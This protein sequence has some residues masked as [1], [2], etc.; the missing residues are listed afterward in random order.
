MYTCTYAPGPRCADPPA[1]TET[2][3]PPPTSPRTA[4][5][6]EALPPPPTPSTSWLGH[7]S[8][9]SLWSPWL[10]SMSPHTTRGCHP[11]VTPMPRLPLQP[12][13]PR[14]PAAAADGRGAQHIPSQITPLSC[15]HPPASQT[16]GI[17]VHHHMAP[18][19]QTITH[20]PMAPPPAT[21]PT[22]PPA[23]AGSSTGGCACPAPL[24]PSL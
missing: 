22:T 6:P 15:S 10:R 13:P 1:T 11:P 16:I 7:L 18:N 5:G 2:P 21:T 19:N 24:T 3:S 4:T 20:P 12:T 23:V 9:S 8:G 14:H 17:T